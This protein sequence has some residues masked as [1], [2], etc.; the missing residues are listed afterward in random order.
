MSAAFT[1]T[2]ANIVFS[3]KAPI[4]STRQVFSLAAASAR[5]A[6]AAGSNTAYLPSRNDMRSLVRLVNR[7]TAS[8]PYAL[9]VGSCPN[10]LRATLDAAIL[11]GAVIRTGESLRM[12]TRPSPHL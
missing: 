4:L 11:S 12:G 2:Y 10:R 7:G 5:P 3:P 1:Y 9:Q 8:S 6:P